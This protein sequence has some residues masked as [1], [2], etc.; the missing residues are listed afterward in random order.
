VAA[1][2]AGL[3]D[4]GY[5]EGKNIV[6]EFRWADQTS[7]SSEIQKKGE[8]GDDSAS[9][10]E[11]ARAVSSSVRSWLPFLTSAAQLRRHLIDC[12]RHHE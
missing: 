1:L 6:I 12:A 11:D 9:Q 5:I 10:M 8:A 7:R 2:R 4:L 3:R